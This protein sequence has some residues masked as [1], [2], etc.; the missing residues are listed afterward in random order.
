MTSAKPGA[1]GAG[2][3]R[4]KFQRSACQRRQ[5]VQF[6]SVEAGAQPCSD[7]LS[8]R[9]SQADR[10]IAAQWASGL[11]VGRLSAFGHYIPEALSVQEVATR[12]GAY[13]AKNS[14][15]ALVLAALT[16]AREYQARP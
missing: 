4:G 14:E 16:L 12:L 3:V 15:H 8:Q 1:A 9:V 5:R 6:Y 10:D 2:H 11:I 7:Y 13:C